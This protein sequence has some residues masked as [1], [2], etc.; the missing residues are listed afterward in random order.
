[1]KRFPF[2][3]C[4]AF[5]LLI[6]QVGFTSADSPTTT[7]TTP[8]MTGGSIYFETN[9]PATIWLD[10]IEGWE[11]VRSPI[12]P[13]KQEHWM[14]VSG[15][16]CTR[17]IPIKLSWLRQTGRFL[18][19]GIPVFSLQ[20]LNR[21]HPLY[22]DNHHD[23][24]YVSDNYPHSLADIITAITGRSRSRYRGS[25]YRYRILCNQCGNFF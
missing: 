3:I 21:P 5:L 11:P 10:N 14:C 12:T 2:L 22:R 15:R 6:V 20:H 18:C 25:R 9:P 24:Q 16:D 4:L 19:P 13:R 1:M 8:G 17:I 23:N 7:T